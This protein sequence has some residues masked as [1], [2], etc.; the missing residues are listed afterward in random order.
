MARKGAQG[1][2]TH[3]CQNQT[4]KG[5]RLHFW[6]SKP[7]RTRSLKKN[8]LHFSICAEIRQIVLEDTPIEL[9]LQGKEREYT[10]TQKGTYY[11]HIFATPRKNVV[12]ISMEIGADAVNTS[13][14]CRIHIMLGELFLTHLDDMTAQWHKIPWE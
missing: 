14:D 10:H 9:F 11:F 7:D 3:I 5:I 4:E 1:S 8:C 13:L 2:G 6:Y 12:L